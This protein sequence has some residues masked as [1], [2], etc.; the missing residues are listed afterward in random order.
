MSITEVARLAG[1]AHGTVSRLINDRGGVAEET[2][3][4]IRKAMRQLG[5]R[6]PPPDRRR[7]R[8]PAPAGIRTG[9]I[10]LLL[11]G[12][13]RGFIERPGVDTAV[14]TMERLLRQHGLNM[15]LTYAAD[16]H[17]LPPIIT[18]RKVDGLF[19]V[20]ETQDSLPK[21]YRSL[22]A[23]WVLSSHAR[24]HR[25][26]DHVLPDNREIGSLAADYLAD[27]R[28][29]RVAFLNDQPKH[30]GFAD[31]GDSF[32]AAAKARQL[33]VS[34]FVA[35]VDSKD[36]RQGPWGEGC[37][38]RQAALVDRWRKSSRRPTGLFVPSDEQTAR[39]YPLLRD[40]AIRPGK[41][42]TIVSCDNQDL[43]LRNLSPRPASIDLNFDLIGQ[44]A[45]DQLLQRIRHPERPAGTRILVAPRL[46]E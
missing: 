25:W 41:D 10:G 17:D 29:R 5:Y 3:Q 23:I 36:D 37:V 30:P 24:R 33:D 18:K 1:V 11:V 7:G 9:N 14:A 22:P 6:P 8:K 45:V 15:V 31:R 46:P 4:R 12:I 16:F 19:L 40:R 28:H 21:S 35:D 2:A 26:A 43:W 20:G 38:S 34:L 27:Q 32:A 44:H 42:C 39:L 13:S